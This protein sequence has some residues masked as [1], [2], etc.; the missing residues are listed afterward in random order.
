MYGFD[1]IFSSSLKVLQSM[2]T[3]FSD[4]NGKS[5]FSICLDDLTPHLSNSSVIIRNAVKTSGFG[6]HN[7]AKDFVP[8]K[9]RDP[10]IR[11]GCNSH[12]R[13]CTIVWLKEL[14]QRLIQGNHKHH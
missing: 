6:R 9:S 8:A 11:R 1:L 5:S 10:T 2:R 7:V 13:K 3:G 14:Q 4:S 12:S